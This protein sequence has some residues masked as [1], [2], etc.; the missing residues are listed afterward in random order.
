MELE[1][2]QRLVVHTQRFG[3][4]HFSPLGPPHSPHPWAWVWELVSAPPLCDGWDCSFLLLL[5]GHIPKPQEAG[6]LA[7][8]QAQDS[9]WEEGALGIPGCFP[10]F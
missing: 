1:I 5:L 4:S 6:S 2:Q 7:S 8:P 9:W 10:H 3:S